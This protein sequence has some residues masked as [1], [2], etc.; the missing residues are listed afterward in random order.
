[1]YLLARYSHTVTPRTTRPRTARTSMVHGFELGPK[2]LD[3]SGFL[4]KTSLQRS[5][6]LNKK[7]NQV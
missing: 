6:G 7:Q 2:L 4:A 3:Q 1:M 5:F